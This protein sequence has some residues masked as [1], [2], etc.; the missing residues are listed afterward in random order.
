MLYD[1]LYCP[2]RKYLDM[3]SKIACNDDDNDDYAD[4]VK[5]AHYPYPGCAFQKRLQF[6]S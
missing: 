3:N 1:H 2:S 4:D 5:D 6:T